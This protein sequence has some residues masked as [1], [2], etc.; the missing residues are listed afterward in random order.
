[1]TEVT[2]GVDLGG[3]KI[4]A[5]AVREGE[6]VGESRRPTPQTGAADVLSAMA[7]SVREVLSA[8]KATV[9]ELRAIGVGTPGQVDVQAGTVRAAS[10]IRGFTDVV[11]LG[12][13]LSRAVGGPP[14]VLDNDVRMATLGEHTR[15][16]GRP[17][18]DLLCV[19]VG[20]GVGGGI[21]LG[22]ELRRGRG[23]AGEIGH[24]VVRLGGRRCPCG[25]RGCLEA[26]AGRVSIEARA[27][28]RHSRGQ[29]TVLF[30]IMERD[31]SGRVT[32]G[33][34]AQ[35]LKKGDPLT[36]TLVEEAVQALGAGIASAQNLLDVEAVILGGGLPDK[37][38]PPFVERVETAMRPHV[39]AVGRSPDVLPSALGDL[40]GAVGAAVAAGG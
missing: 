28:R 2:A 22:G 25:R 9:E 19:F 12:P 38:G 16:A 23:T 6:V 14:V 26:Y 30:Q 10:N 7:E 36:T 40:S 5:V 3:T 33:I 15:G 13:Q 32:S 17:Y 29:R 20:T 4:Q 21:V 24:T 39:F 1:M 11:E 27:R 34:I 35:A 37:L 18:S 8:A 31:G